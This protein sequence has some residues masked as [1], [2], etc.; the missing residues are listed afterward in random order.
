MYAIHYKKE[1]WIQWMCLTHSIE[2]TM[3][4][5]AN[6]LLAIILSILICRWCP[7]DITNKQPAAKKLFEKQNTEFGNRRKCDLFSQRNWKEIQAK[8]T[9]TLKKIALSSALLMV[10]IILNLD[11]VAIVRGLWTRGWLESFAGRFGS[12][13]RKR[14]LTILREFL[15]FSLAS[16]FGCF[17]SYWWAFSMKNGGLLGYGRERI[18]RGFLWLGGFGSLQSE[19]RVCLICRLL[20]SFKSKLFFLELIEKQVEKR[21]D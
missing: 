18:I 3:P 9:L 21:F 14:N 2:Q 6:T 8:C 4:D 1:K 15:A 16:D 5:V 10:M 19:S 20:E 11:R 13:E 17:R 7:S 12:W